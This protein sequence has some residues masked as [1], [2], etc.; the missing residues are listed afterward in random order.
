MR[1][2]E[3]E[4]HRSQSI[5]FCHNLIPCCCTFQATYYFSYCKEKANCKCYAT[6]ESVHTQIP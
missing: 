1:G 4:R 2:R 6:V 5:Q 3:G